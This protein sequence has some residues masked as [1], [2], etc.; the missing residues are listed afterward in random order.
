MTLLPF[1]EKM[2]VLPP[3]TATV[4]ETARDSYSQSITEYPSRP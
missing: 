1:A 4:Y 2:L 3:G